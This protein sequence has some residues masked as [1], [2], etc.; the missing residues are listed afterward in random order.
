[1]SQQKGIKGYLDALIDDKGFR[2]DVAV[3]IPEDNLLKIALY[4]AGAIALGS[5][6]YFTIRHIS[7]KKSI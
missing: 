1:M 4:L 7:N 3:T 6:A 2:T 5:A